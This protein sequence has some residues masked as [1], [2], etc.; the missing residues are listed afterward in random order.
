MS[1]TP[2]EP[3]D[4]AS[5]FAAYEKEQAAAAKAKPKSGK[6]RGAQP[7]EMVSGRIVGF[8]EESAFVDL[9]GKS[10]GVIPLHEVTDADGERTV[11]IGDSVE[12]MVVGTGDDGIQLRVRGGSGQRGPSAPAELAQAQ[13]HGLP[14]QGTVT[15]V[16]KG[17]VEVTVSGVRAFCPISQLDDRYVADAA[18]FV[19]QHLD[20]RITR[21]EEGRGRVTLVLSR[22]ALLEEEKAA[23]AAAVRATLA[24]G[25]VLHGT[26]TSL[27][28]YGAFVDL[29]GVEGLLHVS[30]LGH[31]RVDHPQDVLA[32]GQEVEVQI[33]DIKQD[34]K[35]QERISLSR[36]ALVRDPWQDEA[37]KLK[38]GTRLTGR[39]A[40]LETFGAFVE[41]APGVDGLLHVS[42][43]GGGKQ[44][45]H[46]REVV[47]PG[48]TV[49]VSVKSVDPERRRISLALGAVDELGTAQDVAAEAPGFGAL[50]EFLSRAR[51]KK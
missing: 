48:Q 40:R 39:V 6:A 42:E 26:V 51:N 29:G 13:A 34:A 3:Q 15:G 27:A 28:S 21:L 7:G 22:R 36:R 14:V 18:A 23:R 25:K 37:A 20:F 35:G 47:R 17:G 19:G 2:D 43:M 45:R 38:P 46:P 12:A 5:L 32:V 31:G 49:E 4:F 30:Q 9:G 1:D 16:I 41:L 10:E 33:L 24:P 50:G 44:V 11:R 8:G